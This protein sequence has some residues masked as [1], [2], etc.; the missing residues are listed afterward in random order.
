MQNRGGDRELS[1]PGRTRTLLLVV[2]IALSG[3]VVWR[4]ANAAEGEHTGEAYEETRDLTGPALI[5]A[6]ELQPIVPEDPG[7]PIDPS[8]VCEA[9]AGAAL[10]E[11]GDALYCTSGIA[12]SK[13]E[14]WE[15]GERTK[16]RLPSETEIE[17]MAALFDEG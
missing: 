6:L 15:L 10:V 2:L 14:A 17:R 4:S 12:R 13:V 11:V 8:Q 3:V 16:D 1:V 7:A 5:E 9:T